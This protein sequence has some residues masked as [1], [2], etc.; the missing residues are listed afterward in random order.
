M[1][2]ALEQLEPSA[3]LELFGLL[4]PLDLPAPCERPTCNLRDSS[5]IKPESGKDHIGLGVAHERRRDTEHNLA[6]PGKS[7]GFREAISL[8]NQVRAGTTMREPILGRDHEP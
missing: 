6:R 7:A 8:A 4:R 1:L 5:S 3:P 2:R